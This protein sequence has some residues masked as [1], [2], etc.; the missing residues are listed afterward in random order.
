M[1]I[2]RGLEVFLFLALIL[3]TVFLRKVKL[4]AS[5]ILKMAVFMVLMGIYTLISALTSVMKLFLKR[6]TFAIIIYC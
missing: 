3:K 1:L 6:Y 5:S 4:C 2:L